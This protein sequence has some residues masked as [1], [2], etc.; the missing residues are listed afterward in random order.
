MPVVRSTASSS[1]M[2]PFTVIERGG[3]APRAI[4]E[5]VG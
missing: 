5:A 3:T 2:T 1:A 4:A